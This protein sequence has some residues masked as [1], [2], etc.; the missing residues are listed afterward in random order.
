MTIFSKKK[1]SDIFTIKLEFAT[2]RENNCVASWRCE[3][4][5]RSER[6]WFLH[7]T[8]FVIER[9]LFVQFPISVCHFQNM[10]ISPAPPNF[11]LE[12]S[13]F[14]AF[15]STVERHVV[16]S[17]DDPNIFCINRFNIIAPSLIP[18]LSSSDQIVPVFH[19]CTFSAPK[20]FPDRLKH[21]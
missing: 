1:I 15:F 9:T 13:L 7:S 6:I 20:P 10:M 2:L 4:P 11:T 18:F 14:S 8:W 12:P 19:S 5:W 16:G 21:S 3:P 17:A